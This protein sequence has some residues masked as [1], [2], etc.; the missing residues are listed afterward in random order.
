MIPIG[1]VEVITSKDLRS[2]SWPVW[3]LW[4][5]CATNDHGYVPLVANTSRSFPHSWLIRGFVAKLT[6]RVSLVERQLLTLPK[7]LNSPLVFYAVRVTWSFVSYV[8]FC[9]SLFVLLSFF[10]WPLCPSWFTDS[11]YTCGIF[12]LFLPFADLLN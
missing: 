10:L 3:L 7:Y 8:C 4:N 12:I 1:E 6:R 9:T 11:V 5:I 2:P